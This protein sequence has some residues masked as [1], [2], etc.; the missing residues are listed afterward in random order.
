MVHIQ[1]NIMQLFKRIRVT[2]N[3]CYGAISEICNLKQAIVLNKLQYEVSSPYL[4]VLHPW[5]QSTL[6]WNNCEEKLQKVSKS[7]NWVFSSLATIYIEFTLYW[8][9][10]VNL[11]MIWS[12]LEDCVRLPWWL[13]GKEPTCNVRETRVWSLGWEDSLEQEVATRSG[14]PISRIPWT[15]EP[16]RLQSVD[17][18]RVRCDWACM[19]GGS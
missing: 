19:H 16:G 10:Q 14:I 5:C 6:A 18:Q 13:S 11:E 9:L 12:R 2:D 3:C 15:E 4:R 8:V 7:K 17:L 1:W